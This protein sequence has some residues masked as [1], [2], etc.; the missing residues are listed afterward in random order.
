[1]ADKNTSG[2]DNTTSGA[3]LAL[4]FRMACHGD[5]DSVMRMSEGIY[6]GKDYLPAFFHSFIDDP[7]VIVFLALVG[8]QVVGLRAS[9]ITES[10]TAF[11][12]KAARVAP[13]WRGQG[14]DSRLS[15]HQDDWV[16]QNRPT[17]KYKRSTA[18]SL[19]QG[20]TET[21]KKKMRYIFSMNTRANPTCGGD[22]TP[23]SWLNWTRPA[24]RTSC[25][26]RPQTTTS[27]R[28]Y[29]NGFPRELAVLTTANPSYL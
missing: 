18:F 1:M 2:A 27:V 11:I 5:Y 22:R 17:V 8:D 12:V 26:Y 25:L 13:D 10:G 24:Y 21:M 19:S 6:E 28:L 23:L 9:K 29:R 14:I 7:D 3:D 16:R 4:T 15:V 20:V